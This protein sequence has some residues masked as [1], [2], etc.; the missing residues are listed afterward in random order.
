MANVVVWDGQ[1]FGELDR[2]EAEKLASED[3]VQ[4]VEGPM[5]GT[6][7]KTRDQFGGYRTKVMSA[8]TTPPQPPPDPTSQQQP[9]TG[10]TVRPT[11]VKQQSKQPR[12]TGVKR[13]VGK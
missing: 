2:D 8:D 7:F 10:T 3:K 13:P 4:L 11:G 5:S 12:Q 1:E 6:E 9:K